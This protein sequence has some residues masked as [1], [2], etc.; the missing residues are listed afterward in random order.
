MSMLCMNFGMAY[1][2]E[3]ITDHSQSN[4]EPSNTLPTSQKFPVDIYCPEIPKVYP[5]SIYFGAT[6][7]IFEL[8]FS[9]VVPHV[10]FQEILGVTKDLLESRNGYTTLYSVL[11]AKT[12]DST[13]TYEGVNY[14]FT[15]TNIGVG[16]GIQQGLWTRYFLLYLNIL[17]GLYQS[18]FSASDNSVNDFS[19]NTYLGLTSGFRIYFSRNGNFVFYTNLEVSV[20]FAKK[21]SLTLEDGSSVNP[22]QYTLSPGIEFGI[23]F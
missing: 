1:A 7:P 6:I 12:L 11:E 4:Y 22:N 3:S 21:N 23:G 8:P 10:A 17:P 2:Q 13:A 16:L 9:N 20:D 18:H 14:R 5:W 19:Y 15:K